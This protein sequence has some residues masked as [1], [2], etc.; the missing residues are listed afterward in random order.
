MATRVW[1]CVHSTGNRDNTRVQ[2]GV[3]TA[4]QGR[5]VSSGS[6]VRDGAPWQPSVG[7][8]W[9]QACAGGGNRSNT[10]VKACTAT[11]ST[12]TGVSWRREQ[13][14]PRAGAARETRQHVWPG[15]TVATCM[16]GRGN[17]GNKRVQD[18]AT[19]ATC[20]SRR[21]NHGNMY[22]QNGVT[23]TTCVSR[24]SNHG[25]MYVQKK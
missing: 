5:R 9:R 4:T 11:G 10:G 18:G 16:A 25:N 14:Q 23:T 12:A 2:D 15:G 22:V 8:P 3:T 13:Q 17:H 7:S 24:R 20:M 21:S 6:R 1:G 19:I